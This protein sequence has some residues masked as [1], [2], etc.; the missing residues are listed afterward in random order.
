MKSE[1]DEVEAELEKKAV[2]NELE[3]ELEKKE[4]VTEQA[5]LEAGLETQQ[6]E[7]AAKL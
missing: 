1:Q 6:A 7:L 4:A 3:V 5:E 2:V